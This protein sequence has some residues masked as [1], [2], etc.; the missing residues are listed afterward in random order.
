MRHGSTGAY[1]ARRGWCGQARAARFRLYYVVARKAKD[2]LLK[3]TTDTANV[4]VAAMAANTAKI[5]AK[6][7]KNTAEIAAADEKARAREATTTELLH[8]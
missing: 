2:A 3:T 7:A 5:A 8:Y 4:T 6:A 1:G